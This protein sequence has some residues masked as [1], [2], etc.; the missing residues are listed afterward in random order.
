AVCGTTLRHLFISGGEPGSMKNFVDD[1]LKRKRF[2]HQINQHSEPALFCV[3]H[4]G[5]SIFG[6]PAGKSAAAAQHQSVAWQ[7]RGR[8]DDRTE[9]DCDGNSF[10]SFGTVWPSSLSSCSAYRAEG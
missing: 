2:V 1:S 6:T 5:F 3:R 10:S 7:Q 8:Q 9:G 4:S